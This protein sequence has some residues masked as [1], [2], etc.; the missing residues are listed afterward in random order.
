MPPIDVLRMFDAAANRASEGLRVAEDYL[1]FGLDDAHLTSLAKQLRHDLTTALSVVPEG[2]RHRARNTLGDLGTAISTPTEQTRSSLQQLATANFKRAQ[3]ALRTL[4]ETAKTFDPALSARLEQIRYRTYTLEKAAL[5]T[6]SSLARLKDARLYV[7]VDGGSDAQQ[8]AARIA[9]LLAAGVH[10]IQLRDKRLTDRH[11]LER[12]R[13]LRRLTKAT[14]TLM[15][16]NDRPD[17]AALSGADGV[18]LGQDELTVQDA[19]AIVGPDALVG[20]STHDMPQARQAVLQGADYLG[21]GPIFPSG[22]KTFAE[23]PGL[24]FARAVSA[25]ICLPA[26]AIGGIHLGNLPELLAT[27]IRRVAVSGAINGAADEQCAA[28]QLL[29]ALGD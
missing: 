26:F 4:E 22:T 1:R 19:R 18:H 27:G 12:A 5:I 13:L 21:V 7:L 10:L 16:V 14:P 23:F 29:R 28:E 3:Q 6:I 2:E 15:I 8:F 11:L 17:I 24:E 9:R 25:E 20:V